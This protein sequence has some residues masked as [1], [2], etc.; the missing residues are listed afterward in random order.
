MLDAFLSPMFDDRVSV[1]SLPAELIVLAV[2]VGGVVV[3]LLW[4]RRIVTVESEPHSF[5]ATA[6]RPRRWPAIAAV[7]AVVVLLGVLFG[8]LLVALL[9]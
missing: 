5:R 4:L 1:V 6:D 7:L 3:G 2:G 8:V 9:R